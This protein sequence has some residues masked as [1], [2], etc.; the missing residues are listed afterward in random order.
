MFTKSLLA[1][2]IA[3]TTMMSVAQ[4]Q[5]SRIRA[6]GS[7][8]VFPFTSAVAEQY[9]K[10]TGAPAPIIESIG[11]GG[12]FKA[13]CAGIGANEIDI[14]NA[15]RRIKSSEK[16]KCQENGITPVEIAVGKDGI[17]II[18]SKE[19]G[20]YDMSVADVRNA[21][22]QLIYRNDEVIDNNF[23]TWNEIN[24]NLP[25]YPIKVMGPPKSSGTRDAFTALVIS[26]GA[27]D[28]INL[29][30]AVRKDKKAR[31]AVMK[32]VREDGGYIEAGEHD[33]LLV[34]K[35]VADDKIMGILGYSFYNANA[36]KLNAAT[37]NG[38]EPTA[39]KIA[40]GEYP[41]ARNLYIYVKKEHITLKPELL[42]FVKEYLSDDAAGE[43]GYLI[44]EG[45]ISLTAADKAKRDEQVLNAL[46]K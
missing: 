39:E 38:I 2:T 43:F 28:D 14:A 26:N 8:T 21:V 11:T 46:S 17:A 15:S 10:K 20:Q 6:A 35:V 13:F 37:I 9:A 4:A 18:S 1:T 5:D 12:G 45:L 33:N 41:L 25:N 24:S 7:S 42:D 32:N 29:L 3:L 22:A 34:K 19:F 30:L 36:S 27:K 40:S 23:K 31:K 16:K 44:D